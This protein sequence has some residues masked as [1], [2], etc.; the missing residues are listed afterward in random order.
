MGQSYRFGD[1]VYILYPFSDHSGAKDRPAVVISCP[2]FN[3]EKPEII[4]LPVTSQLR[5][6]DTYG[7]VIIIDW[8]KAGLTQPSVIK[9]FPHTGI[10][11]QVRR[12]IGELSKADKAQ[13]LEMLSEV[14]SETL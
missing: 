13:V 2:K 6:A 4:L 11:A 9:P 8:Q 1:V 7:T 3:H 10:Q 14:L 5:H 12:R